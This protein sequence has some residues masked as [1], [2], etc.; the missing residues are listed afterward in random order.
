LIVAWDGGAHDALEPVIRDIYRRAEFV[1]SD[2][3]H[4]LVIGMTE[5]AL[6]VGATVGSSEKLDRTFLGAGIDGV[7]FEVASLSGTEITS[8]LEEIRRRGPELAAATSAAKDRLEE[9][10]LQIRGFVLDRQ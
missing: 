1:V 8:R 5:G 3:L 2:R 7:S 10:S 6:P 9:L 4:A